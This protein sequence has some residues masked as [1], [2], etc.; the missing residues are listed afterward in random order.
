M[1]IPETMQKLNIFVKK[2]DL[3]PAAVALARLG[4]LHLSGG[5]DEHW[6]DRTPEWRS[7]VD[8]FEDHKHRLEKLAQALQITDRQGQPPQDLDPRED[9]DP[10]DQSLQEI[11]STVGDWRK[12]HR[13]AQNDAE[14]VGNRIREMHLL[15]GLE[16]PIEEI[17]TSEYLH[18]VVGT[19]PRKNL[20]N[21]KVVLFR[22]PFVI[23]P[24][25]V[26]DPR[27][28]VV[29]ATSRNFREILDRALRAIFFEPVSLEVDVRGQPAEVLDALQ[30]QQAE[31][32]QRLADLDKA[33][34]DLAERF[35]PRLAGLRD[36][37][38]A[39]LR[40]ARAVTGFDRHGDVFLISGWIPQRSVD[41]LMTAVESATEGRS[42]VELVTPVPGGRRRTPT[43]LRNPRILRP[44]EKIV[45]IF[46][47]PDYGE[48]DPTPLVAFSFVLMYGMM[49]GDVGHGLMLATL[50]VLLQ[51]R[52][53]AKA[54]AVGSVL[55]TAGLSATVFG[56]LYGS[57]FG[58]EDVLPALWLHPL[59]SILEI[60]TASIVAGIGLINIGFLIHLLKS[61]R[62]RNWG[63]FFFDRNGMAGIGLYWAIM[64]GG[65]AALRQELPLSVLAVL[66]A[67]PAV[68]V[69]LQEPLARLVAGERPLIE[70]DWGTFGAQA[71]FETFETLM[72]FVSNSL[73]FVRLGA[74]AVAHAAFIGVVFSVAEIGGEMLRWPILLIGTLLVV[75]FEGLIVGI[76]ALRLE[77]YEFFS[78]FYQGGGRRFAPLRLPETNLD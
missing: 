36:R 8:A 57:V 70:E 40:V 45:A 78:K 58:R 19:I 3:K 26:E 37:I 22:V 17:R 50:G 34:A 47:Y 42:D 38:E 52:F 62:I 72:R 23:I 48:I 14:Q 39:D 29:A 43:F 10:I 20:E 51:R 55:V 30:R 2:G 7:L 67:A 49:F 9:P 65:Y 75:G 66:I 41:A 28:L 24:I 1:F 11:E 63:A 25:R 5:G 27:V 76:Q 68:L 53:A 64:G 35:A 59:G 13:Q 33:R 54:A 71:F 15:A 56:F 31:C 73:S 6:S 69:F 12:N 77:Y 16:T 46:G 4:R 60:L 44:F 61:V 32:E 18:R 74:F 21:L